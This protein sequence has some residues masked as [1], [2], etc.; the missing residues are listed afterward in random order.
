MSKMIRRR[1][2]WILGL[3]MIAAVVGG[4]WTFH[5]PAAAQDSGNLLTNGSFEPP[6][7]GQGAPTRTVPNGWTLLVASGSPDAFPHNDPV[8]ILDGTVSWNL[9][10]SYTAF[11]AVAYQRVG[12]LKAGDGVR[13]TAYGWVYTC[14]NTANS[15]VIANPPYRQSDTSAGAQLR[16]GIDPNGGTDPTSGNVKWSASAAPYDQW[17][18]MSVSATAAGDAVTMYLYMTQSA[19]LAINN[20]YWDKAS[21]VRTQIAPDATATPNQVPFV[22]PQNVRPDGSIVHVVQAGDTLSSIAYAYRDY[23]VTNESIA[24]LN[25]PMKPNTRVLQIGQKIVILPPGSV[26]P[27]TGQLL[28]AG[29]SLP[30]AAATPVA[31]ATTPLPIA[32]ESTPLAGQSTPVAAQITPEATVPADASVPTYTTVKAAFLPFEHG[33]MFWVEDTNQILVLVDGPTPDSGTMSQ[34]QDTW[35]EGMPETDPSLAP[36]EGFTQ[37]TR[38]FGQAWRTYP[39]VKDSLGWSIGETV[40]F[41]ALV[42]RQKDRAILNG[43]DNRVYELAGTGTWAAIDYYAQQ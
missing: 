37:P 2:Q 6:Y 38:S 41:T 40:N 3:M 21:L 29:S 26:D 22:K 4:M 25:P 15:C 16:V 12:G 28:P 17:A 14:N 13:A 19:G 18:E 43:P 11:T 1:Y 36:P 35:R 8:Q 10:Q 20:V 42:V 31:A 39:G 23:H 24:A 27:A 32:G 5:T 33:Y 30:P 7:A 34:Y 9:H